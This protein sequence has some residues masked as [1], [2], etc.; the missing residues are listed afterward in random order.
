ME[1]RQQKLPLCSQSRPLS[2]NMLSSPVE[3]EVCER[4]F[5][6]FVW[7]VATAAAKMRRD[8]VRH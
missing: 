2:L 7:F 8:M 6:S 3:A 4:Q 1:K 5:F